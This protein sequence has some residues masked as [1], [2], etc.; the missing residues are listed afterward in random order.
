MKKNVLGDLCLYIN[1][2]RERER[3]SGCHCTNHNI[4]YTIAIDDEAIHVQIAAPAKVG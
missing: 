1:V 2:E 4:K 3:R